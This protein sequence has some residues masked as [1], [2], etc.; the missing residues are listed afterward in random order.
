M[1]TVPECSVSDLCSCTLHVSPSPTALKLSI[2]FSSEY[3]KSSALDAV[4]VE[5]QNEPLLASLSR[6]GSFKCPLTGDVLVEPFR[7]MDVR[8]QYV[9]NLVNSLRTMI[10]FGVEG[11]RCIIP[12]TS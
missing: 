11:C 6:F 9:D 10:P 7:L 2:S 8:L 1:V 5:L 4:N 12:V 3:S